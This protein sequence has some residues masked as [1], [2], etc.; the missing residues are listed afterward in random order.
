MNF[1]Q[2][3]LGMTHHSTLAEWTLDEGWQVKYYYSLWEYVK[4]VSIPIGISFIIVTI[5]WVMS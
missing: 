3:I 1:R 4:G 2:N 5:I